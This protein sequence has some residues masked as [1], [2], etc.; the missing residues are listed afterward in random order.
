MRTVIQILIVAMLAAILVAGEP[1]DNLTDQ[2]RRNVAI[3]TLAVRGLPDSVIAQAKVLPFLP[4]MNGDRKVCRVNKYL[5]VSQ[6]YQYI[7]ILDF[8]PEPVCYQITPL[9]DERKGKQ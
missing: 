8:G 5:F 6:D 1:K 4:E 3:T 9:I 2:V 7:A